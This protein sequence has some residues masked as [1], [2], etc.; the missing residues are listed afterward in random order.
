MDPLQTFLF[1]KKALL[2]FLMISSFYA[3]MSQII[4]DSSMLSK[5]AP[6]R[7]TALFETTKGDFT[8]EVIREWS[9]MGADRL[10]QL[11]LTHFYDN[12]GIFRVQP[13][14]VIQFGICNDSALNYFWDK[15]P[16]KDEPAMV[17]NLKYTISYARD[18]AN[19]RTVQLFINKKDNH[20]LDT[21]NYNGLRGFTPVARI[22]RGMDVIDK[23]Y[24]GYGFDPTNQQ[25]SIMQKGNRWLR[26]K[27]PLIDYIKSAGIKE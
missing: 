26:E 1:M 5:K 7:F 6:A 20:K 13:E 24:A 11:L 27:Y 22:I 16:L 9:P 19:S 4:P 14:Y 17:Q 23:F 25:D 10:Y 18:G 8:I 15:R 2:L 12:N 3:G 21:V